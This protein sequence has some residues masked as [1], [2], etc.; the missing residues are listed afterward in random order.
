VISFLNALYKDSLQTGGT[1]RIREK[2]PYKRTLS[3]ALHVIFQTIPTTVIPVFSRPGN[4]IK[5]YD[6]NNAKKTGIQIKV[7]QGIAVAP[8]SVRIQPPHEA[9]KAR[10]IWRRDALERRKPK[11]YEVGSLKSP[12]GGGL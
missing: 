12:S 9:S 7:L 5:E 6:R 8:S 10:A 1:T 2:E 11:K 4:C 3:K